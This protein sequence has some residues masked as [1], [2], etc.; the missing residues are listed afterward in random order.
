MSSFFP[1][2]C[3]FAAAAAS[4][5]AVTHPVFDRLSRVRRFLLGVVLRQHIDQP[6][7]VYLPLGGTWKGKACDR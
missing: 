2:G 7:E 4:C 3:D 6:N 5:T 1:F